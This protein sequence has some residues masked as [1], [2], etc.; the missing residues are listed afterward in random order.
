MERIQFE[1]GGREYDEKYPDGIPTTVEIEHA[2]LGVLSSGLVMYPEGHARRGDERLLSLLE[3][4]FQALAGP[5]VE[6]F[7]TLRGRW[8]GLARKS[9][10]DVRNLY[11]FSIRC[12]ES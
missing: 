7:D 5:A 1:H 10:E 4:K 3:H 2:R 9:A 8:T 11:A 12:L 6:E